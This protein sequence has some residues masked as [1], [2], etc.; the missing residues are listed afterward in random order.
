MLI[1]TKAVVTA[2]AFGSTWM[3]TRG[4]LQCLVMILLA[5]LFV[6][7]IRPGSLWIY[8]AGLFAALALNTVVPLDHFLG[9][10]R[11]M[12]VVLSCRWCSHLCCSL[13]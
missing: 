9:M 1:E 13:A 3:V 4:V 5:N 11:T 7:K 8:Y 10:E 12:Q 2:A 6:L